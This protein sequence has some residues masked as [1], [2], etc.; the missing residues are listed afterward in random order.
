VVNVP[1]PL[2]LLLQGLPYECLCGSME[3]GIDALCDDSRQCRPG[4]L[5]VA[6]RGHAHDGHRFIAEAIRNGARGVLCEEPPTQV[7]DGCT[8]VCTPDT[9]TALAVVAH[10][11][12]GEPSRALR[13]IG[14]T[15][16][17][18]KTTTTFFVRRVLEKAGIP[19]GVIGTTG[20]YCGDERRALRHT[21]PTPIEFCSLLAWMRERGSHAVVVEVSSHALDQRR[22]EAIHFAAGLF[23]NLSHD[24]LD[25]HGTL[26]AYAQAKRHLFELLPPDAV[27]FACDSGDGWGTFMLAAARCRMRYRVGIG[28]EADIPLRHL[29]A[30]RTGIRW[31]MCL[32]NC[33][34]WIPFQ[35]RLLGEYNAFN[36]ALAVALGWSWGVELRLLQEAIAEAEPPPGRMEPIALPNGALALVDY[37]HTPDAL[38][39]VLQAARCLLSAGGRL[40]CV[41]GC[42]GERDRAKRP[43]MGAIAAQWADIV[44]LT[45]DNPRHEP[46]E[47]IL[48][49]IR[50]GIPP[51][52]AARVLVIPERSE[53]LWTAA[54]MSAAGDILLVAGK[55]HEEYQVLG[56]RVVPFSDREALRTIAQWM[57]EHMSV[58]DT[59]Q[60]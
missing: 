50:S 21:T 2:A 60:Q 5:F 30:S 41:F 11:F 1:V 7:P 44:V 43:P 35:S 39:R 40:I 51:E 49:D 13:I 45:N 22:V 19:T 10:R 38:Q 29:Q 3:I 17:N 18:G 15:G 16:T 34:E 20:A 58:S 54:Q 42:G 9:R 8:V 26:E 46:P 31:E 55:G 48:E 52:A 37:A 12:F 59:A 33:A 53:A 24:H 14:V 36:A 57:R 56:D 28:T 47:R 6:V 27:A 4:A 32:P 23:T 25:Y